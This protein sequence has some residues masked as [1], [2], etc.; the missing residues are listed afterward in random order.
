MNKILKFKEIVQLL[1]NPYN[2]IDFFGEEPSYIPAVDDE[3]YNNACEYLECIIQRY[4]N[5]VIDKNEENVTFQ[6]SNSILFI[7]EVKDIENLI[8]AQDLIIKE[9][10]ARKLRVFKYEWNNIQ[11]ILNEPNS[12]YD[13]VQ[14]INKLANE[15]QDEIKFLDKRKEEILNIINNTEV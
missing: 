4:I 9:I 14:K 12:G 15:C 3:K 8:T 1:K 5:A 2:F 13:C 6:N 10:E 7:I 11:K